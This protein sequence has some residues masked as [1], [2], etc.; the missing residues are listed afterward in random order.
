MGLG[1]GTGR[2]G[3][4]PN[5]TGRPTAVSPGAGETTK[6]TVALGEELLSLLRAKYPGLSDQDTVRAGASSGTAAV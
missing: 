5:Q 2:G 1:T 6:I 3:K 4:R